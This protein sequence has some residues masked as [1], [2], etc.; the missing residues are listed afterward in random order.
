L[1]TGD[2]GRI[3]DDDYLTLA[4]RL[5]ESYRCGGEQVLPSEIEDLLVTHPAVLQAHVVPVPDERMG[6]IGVAC[7]V[8]RES[9]QATPD[10]LMAFCA[11]RLARF[12]VPRHVIPLQADE[13]PVT[14]S[15]RARK[16]LLTRMV[17]ATLGRE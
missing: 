4:G 5:K 14:P 15:G 6:E 8:L 2:L 12:K 9:A 1:R 7:V 13:I 17:A 16:F 3:D 11:S 10:E